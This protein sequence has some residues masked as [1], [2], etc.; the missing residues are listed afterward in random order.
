MT[1]P[2]QKQ[3]LRSFI[4][5]LA[6]Q[7][8]WPEDLAEQASA[9]TADDPVYPEM[10]AV[11]NGLVA[12]IGAG[13]NLGPEEVWPGVKERFLQVVPKGEDGRPDQLELLT[14]QCLHAL[15]EGA[16]SEY[17]RSRL[18]AFPGP[19]AAGGFSSA[20][21]YLVYSVAV[22]LDESPESVYAGVRAG[23]YSGEGAE[24]GAT[25]G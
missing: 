9:L 1:T 21:D 11:A 2:F 22:E 12:A 6:E 5:D 24:A 15:S 8:Q 19:Y 4:A 17:F 13:I 7:D 3:K 20:I 25:Q 10:A 18:E 23:Q 14:Y 16:E